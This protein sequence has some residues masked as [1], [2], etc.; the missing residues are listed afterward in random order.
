MNAFMSVTLRDS[1]TP[2][3]S[4]HIRDLMNSWIHRVMNSWIHHFDLKNLPPPGGC[5]I[6]YVPWSRAVCKRFHDE[7]R[8]SHLFMKSLT[9]GSW[10][11]NIVNRKPPRGGGVL[12]IKVM[13]SWIHHLMSAWIYHLMNSWIHQVSDINAETRRE[14]VTSHLSMSHVTLWNGSWHTYEGVMFSC[15][16]CECSVSSRHAYEGTDMGWLWVVGSLKL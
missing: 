15:H 9:H 8:R 10:S 1:F 6:Y 3:L 7:M 13:N 4:I 5:S 12:S 2:C 11:G 16:T 14:W